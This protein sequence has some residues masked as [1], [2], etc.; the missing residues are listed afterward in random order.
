MYSVIG[1]LPNGV[2]QQRMPI[3]ITPIDRQRQLVGVEL[4]DQGRQEGA[5]LVVHGAVAIEQLV[6]R[7]G[8]PQAGGGDIFAP[9]DVFQK[10]QHV[11]RPF[12]PAKRHEQ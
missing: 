11:V 1:H 2:G 7:G 12:G 10:R 3:A 9:D 8:L 5:V 6:P 4:R